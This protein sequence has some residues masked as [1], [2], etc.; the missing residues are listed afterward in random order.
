MKEDIVTW[1]GYFPI[2]DPV[3]FRGH[4]VYPVW[5]RNGIWYEAVGDDG[6]SY[7]RNRQ[8]PVLIPHV[9]GRPVLARQC[10]N[11]GVLGDDLWLVCRVHR[12]RMKEKNA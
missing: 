10:P 6:V 9:S 2:P 12:D 1:D 4:A 8:C 11:W 3:M 5:S 7:S